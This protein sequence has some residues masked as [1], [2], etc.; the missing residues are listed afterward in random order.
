LEYNIIIN[1][2]IKN[3]YISIN[4]IQMKFGHRFRH[5]GK[6]L[7]HKINKRAHR[8]GHK[9]NDVIDK[10]DKNIGKANSIVNKIDDGMQ[11][12]M[13]MGAG[14]LPLGV[15]T[16]L[17]ALTSGIHQ[18]RLASNRVKKASGRVKDR[19]HEIEKF[20]PRKHAQQQLMENS[21]NGF[22]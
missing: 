2:K 21:S 22:A 10:V 16:G 20:N 9:V 7:G 15:G 3:K 18:G 5:A 4:Y 19:G 6:R 13:K 1:Y 8:I 14:S 17:T 12:G 11:L